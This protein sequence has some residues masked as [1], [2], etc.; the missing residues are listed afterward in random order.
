MT[1]K[2]SDWEEVAALADVL[3]FLVRTASGNGRLARAKLTDSLVALAGDQTIT[4]NKTFSGTSR[5]TGTVRFEAI[6]KYA[7]PASADLV[8][9][10]PGP[11][12]HIIPVPTAGLAALTV[13]MS[14]YA[15]TGTDV[16]I[17]FSGPVAAL[18]WQPGLVGFGTPTIKGAP[19][20]VVA[21]RCVHMRF[22]GSD[23]TWYV[24]S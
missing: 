17:F 14:D 13:K 19:S 7:I 20:A 11:V 4:G 10:I 3:T 12:T 1:I 24:L 6:L 21:N 2:T 15:Q 18:T 23:Q 22:D 5:F 8:S 9:L 16:F